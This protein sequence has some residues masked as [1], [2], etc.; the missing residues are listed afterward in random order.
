MTEKHLA[1][2]PHE[3]GLFAVETNAQGQRESR[4]G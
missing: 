4:F 2:N 1:N 3:G